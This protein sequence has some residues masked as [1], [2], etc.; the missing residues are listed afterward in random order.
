MVVLTAASM[1]AKRGLKT[2]RDNNGLRGQYSVKEVSTP[3]AFN[4]NPVLV[5]E[6]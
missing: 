5:L 4:R 1:S 6:S 2:F 3:E